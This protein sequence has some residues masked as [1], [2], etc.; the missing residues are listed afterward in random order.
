MM[1]SFSQLCL[2][3]AALLAFTVGHGPAWAHG[4]HDEPVASLFVN[5]TTDD[6]HRANM[7]L[8]F[9]SNQLNRGHPVT[10]FLND[11]GV[12]V[13]AKANAATFADHHAAM[14]SLL[15][16]GATILVCPMCMRHYGVVEEDLLDGLLMGNPERTGEALF[17]ANTRT[18]TW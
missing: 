8:S 13:G 4:E 18:L 9:S 2:G 11:R 10:I 12:L 15:E 6:P 3:F 17:R 16:R 7:A 5:M 1:R 14:A